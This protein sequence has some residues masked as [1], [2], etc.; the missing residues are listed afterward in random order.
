MSI[1]SA[2]S[3]VINN[4]STEIK[5]R[6]VEVGSNLKKSTE[7][8]IGEVVIKA[9]VNR[10]KQGMLNALS[11]SNDTTKDNGNDLSTNSPD[12]EDVSAPTLS[13]KKKQRQIPLWLAVP[14]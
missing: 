9:A 5:N 14:V 7:E 1:L 13:S 4:F 12:I 3:R 2:V 10:L 11:S 6:V 8:F